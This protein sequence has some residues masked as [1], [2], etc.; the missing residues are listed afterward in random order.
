MF[1]SSRRRWSKDVR[2]H[3][4]WN[5]K[6]VVEELLKLHAR[7]IRA[8]ANAIAREAPGLCR[9]IHRHIGSMEAVRKAAGI[10][11]P[12]RWSKAKILKELRERARKGQE[13]ARSK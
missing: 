8:S 4:R 13:L 6:L 9:A 7:G 10:G 5:K 11:F 12:A 1:F 3:R 2:R